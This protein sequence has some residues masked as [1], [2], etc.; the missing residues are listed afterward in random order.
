MALERLEN[1]LPTRDWAEQAFGQ[2]RGWPACVAAYQER[3]VVGGSRDLPDR[4]WFSRTGHPFDFNPVESNDDE[5]SRSGSWAIRIPGRRSPT[6][7]ATAPSA[8]ETSAISAIHSTVPCPDLLRPHSGD[9]RFA[10]DRE[11]SRESREAR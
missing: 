9:A 4:L 3:L 11:G 10:R 6:S 7:H 1:G 2:A 8:A 5:R